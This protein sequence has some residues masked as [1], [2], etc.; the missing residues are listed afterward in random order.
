MATGR[1]AGRPRTKKGAGDKFNDITPA[2]WE[3]VPPFPEGLN[4]DGENLWIKIWIGAGDWLHVSDEF[5]ITELC[6]IFQDKELYRRAL[7]LGEVKRVY[8]LSNKTLIAHP[9]V[10]MLKDARVQMNTYFSALGFSPSDRAKIAI[11]NLV[12][13]DEML[14]MMKA[15]ITRKH[16]R[17][18]SGLGASSDGE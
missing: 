8:M 5:M 9:Y 1:P 4:E 17:A 2:D 10:G 14:E 13:E 6:Q 16:E 12:A 7:E 3:K 15:K 11:D 18:N